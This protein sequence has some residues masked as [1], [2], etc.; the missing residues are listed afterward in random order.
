[1]CNGNR[2]SHKQC[3]CMRH[4][5]SELGEGESLETPSSPRKRR[6]FPERWALSFDTQQLQNHWLKGQKWL[7]RRQE[8]LWCGDSTQSY[9]DVTDADWWRADTL[10]LEN[11]TPSHPLPWG[12]TNEAQVSMQNE[13]YSLLLDR[14]MLPYNSCWEQNVCVIF[15]GKYSAN[16][17][18]NDYS[19]WYC[20]HSY[21]F[22]LAYFI[23]CISNTTW[24]L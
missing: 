22:Q 1:M 2:K 24:E 14:V 10:L 3:E 8:W 6:L 17:T 11:L 9:G 7:T 12:K 13:L 15:E 5:E 19:P 20:N 4:G 23:G 18:I 16:M 21:S